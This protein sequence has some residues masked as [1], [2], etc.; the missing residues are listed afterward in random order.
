MG[1]TDTTNTTGHSTGSRLLDASLE[2]LAERGYRGA[3]TR[4]IARRAGVTEL[5]LFRHFGTKDALLREAVQQFSRPLNSLVPQPSGD[6]RQ[7]LL[8]LAHQAAAA[9]EARKGLIARI[10]PEIIRIPELMTSTG[11]F[12]I[13]LLVDSVADLL[14]HYQ[15]SRALRDMQPR[16]LAI[17]FLGPLFM[18]TLVG[19]IWKMTVPF[20]VERHVEGFLTGYQVERA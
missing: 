19:G 4:E 15:V 7:D 18:Q 12:G 16:E 20:D 10:M 1:D 3:T 13:P 6:L 5:T 9:F 17:T 14:H 8:L 2:L 11:R